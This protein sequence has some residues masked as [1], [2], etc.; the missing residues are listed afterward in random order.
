MPE[1][2]TQDGGLLATA[3]RLGQ[4]VLGLLSTRLELAAIEL[5]EEKLRALGLLAWLAAAL[6]LAIAGILLAVG[7]L[8][9]FLWR[10]A[11]YA[12]LVGLTV[13]VLGA[14]ATCFYVM[15]RRVVQGP[16]PFAATVA[17]FRKDAACLR[18]PE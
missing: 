1:G 2:E 11:G 16:K 8:A 14:A 13:V 4:S 18:Q 17:E 5:Q 3:R 15:R 7:T 10:Q 12:G 9:L 6:A